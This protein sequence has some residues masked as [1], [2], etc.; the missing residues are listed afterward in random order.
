M[1]AV[2]FQKN[3]DSNIYLVLFLLRSPHSLLHDDRH[4]KLVMSLQQASDWNV[5]QTLYSD[6]SKRI[7]HEVQKTI[8]VP[9][10]KAGLDEFVFLLPKTILVA[11]TEAYHT[12]THLSI[13]FD[14]GPR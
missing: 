3:T 1:S 14:N 2:C 5:S 12:P 13:I 8:T 9:R 11:R 7:K 10:G 6:F 4:C